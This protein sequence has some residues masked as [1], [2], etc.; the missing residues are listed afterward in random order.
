MYVC[1][2]ISL[3]HKGFIAPQDGGKSQELIGFFFFF[4]SS[5]C[6]NS[7]SSP[8][9]PQIYITSLIDLDEGLNKFISIRGA[10][11]PVMNF[12]LGCKQGINIHRLYLRL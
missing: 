6:L 5:S 11:G 10:G 9:P 8:S 7:L 12:A 1:M 2:Y 3:V 4:F